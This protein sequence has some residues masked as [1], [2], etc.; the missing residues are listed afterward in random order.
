MSIMKRAMRVAFANPAPLLFWCQNS[1][2][3]DGDGDETQKLTISFT[4]LAVSL[5]NHKLIS[6]RFTLESIFTDRQ[7]QRQQQLCLR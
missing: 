4:S 5:C 7:R 3:D 6:I 1:Y 2:D